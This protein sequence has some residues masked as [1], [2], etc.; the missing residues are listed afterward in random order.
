MFKKIV[1]TNFVLWNV[2][3]CKRVELYQLFRITYGLYHHG[4][5]V[6]MEHLSVEVRY[7]SARPHGVTYKKTTMIMVTDVRI[8][9]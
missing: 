6:M 7:T 9:K 3:P 8:S 2:K 4:T 1:S 5:R